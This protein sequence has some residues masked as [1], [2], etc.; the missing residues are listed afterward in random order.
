MSAV[1]N[2]RLVLTAPKTRS[3]KNWVAISPRVAAALERRAAAR[4][5]ADDPTDQYTGLVF[6][7][8]NG[9]PLRPQTVLDRFRRL[10]AEAGV[11]RVTLHDLRHLAA[12]LTI[13]A[14]IP[15][16]VVS[17]TLRHSTLSTTAN[18]YSHLT[19]QAARSAVDAIDTPSPTPT[20]T[21]T[22]PALAQLAATTPRP[23]NLARQ[24]AEPR[25]LPVPAASSPAASQPQGIDATTPR[26]PRPQTRK[27]PPPHL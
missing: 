26:P 10:A 19:Q 7:R 9:R 8:P 3:S 6:C 11:P 17:K 5:T 1:D 24:P 16:T 25:L 21:V 15:L 27:R 18:I 12:A 14:G 2:A 22:A 4:N 13:T 20:E 23:L